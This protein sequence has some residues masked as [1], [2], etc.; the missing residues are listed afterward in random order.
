MELWE[1]W[2]FCNVYYK[3]I[4]KGFLGLPQINFT[5][6]GVVHLTIWETKPEIFKCVHKYYV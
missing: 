4:I 6:Q 2:I 5:A 3:K 1:R